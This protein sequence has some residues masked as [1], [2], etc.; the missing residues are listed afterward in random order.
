[1]KRKSAVII[2]IVCIAGL[3]FILLFQKSSESEVDNIMNTDK[4]FKF[5]PGIPSDPGEAG[6]RTLEGTD[7]DHDGLRDDLQRWI[8]ARFP[9]DPKKRN[10]LKQ[11]AI[12]YQ[13]KLFLKHDSSDM[14][15]FNRMEE[16]A[17]RC[18]FDVF[19]NP[20][21]AYNE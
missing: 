10:A 3:M 15:Q 12:T 5:P 20:D 1:M 14:E 7:S 19:S 21:D 13:R 9:N 4:H 16:K 17:T 18:L 2:S 11:N 6:K 8:Y